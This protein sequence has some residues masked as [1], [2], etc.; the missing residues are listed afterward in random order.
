MAIINRRQ[1]MEGAA[2]LL[3]AAHL[4]WAFAAGQ[5]GGAGSGNAEGRTGLTKPKNL[6]SSTF[7]PALFAKSLASAAAWHP[8]PKAEEREAWESIPSDVRAAAVQRAEAILGTEWVSLPASVYLEFKRTGNRSHF[9]SLYFGRRERLG[10]LVLGECV[11]GKGRFLDEITNG[12][13]LICEETSW[14]IPA[15]LNL[16]REGLASGLPIID[17]PTVALFS[18]ET[19]ATLAWVYYLVGSRLDGISPLITRR[20]QTETKRRILDP[21][22]DRDDFW[23]M[24]GGVGGK[25]HL[26]NWN[27]WI[28]SNWMAANLLLEKDEQQRLM[29]MSKICRSLDLYLSEY[30]PDGGCEEGPAY[31][32]V[33]A[34]SYFDCC[35]TLESAT[36][37]VAR[38]LEHPFIRAMEHYIVDVHIANRYYVNY[39][40][41]HANAAPTPELA[42]RIGAGVG[43]KSLEEF[44]A[45]LMPPDATVGSGGLGRLS[46]A[47]PDILSSAK[48]RSAAKA[49]ALER[50]AWYPALALMTAR[51]KGGSSDGFYLAVQAAAN[52]RSHGHNDSGSF[53]VFHDGE[54][55]FIDVGV[56]AYT[57]KTFS[58]ERYTIWTMQSAYHNLPTVG[59][60]M[61]SQAAGYRAGDIR[62]ASD[63]SHAGLA[64]NLA[65]AYPAEAGIT[66]WM[67]EITL[68]RK[69]GRILLSEDFE[70]QRKVPVALSFMTPRVPTQG[71][72]GSV[73]L[74]A[75]DKSVR[76]V[77]LKYDASFTKPSFEKIELKDEGL[78]HTWGPA[79]YR[80]LLS[81]I[82]P[83]DGGKWA[84]AMI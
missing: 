37:G 59:G 18:A 79:I 43:D 73:I 4:P 25:T 36:G 10:D 70:L 48:V 84:I 44:G 62:Y 45:F 64:M 78:Q 15:C 17:E 26:N 61:Q 49:D 83:V 22:M 51:V 81:S 40:D 71:P 46:R 69:A 31:W 27:P 2:A 75:A 30:S 23:W 47:I 29:A 24:W 55:V 53:I 11:E 74:S 3:G 33:S 7:T 21:A 80:V 28:N 68:D 32:E 65:T 39:G 56:E 42:Y 58:A 19:G 16:Q 13:W 77:T 82:E 38:V 60:V 6:L 57:A 20:I 50:D 72:Q 9:E 5:G 63:D 34:A 66:R 67:R 12:V 54:P 52:Q 8:Y 76:N 14:T 1:L 35:T 41:A